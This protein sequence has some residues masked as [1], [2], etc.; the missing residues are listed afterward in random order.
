MPILPVCL[1]KAI[2]KTL[3]QSILQIVYKTMLLVES[4]LNVLE[5]CSFFG[6]RFNVPKTAFYPSVHE[7]LRS[8][9]TPSP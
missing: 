7:A 1:L 6:D 4:V 2:W 3:D 8:L 9:S 5:R